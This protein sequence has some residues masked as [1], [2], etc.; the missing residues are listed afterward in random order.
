MFQSK[1]TGSFDGARRAR[2]VRERVRAGHGVMKRP[3]YIGIRIHI[4][5]YTERDKTGEKN[6]E[7]EEQRESGGQPSRVR[8]GSRHRQ[9]S[10]ATPPEW[11]GPGFKRSPGGGRGPSMGT[12]SFD[13][14]GVLDRLALFPKVWTT[15]RRLDT[16]PK[17][18]ANIPRA[19][20]THRRFGQHPEG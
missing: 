1:E 10:E 3:L 4:C 2:L 6:G 19:R 11:N 15:S 12:G 9:P 7:R 5:I 17:G 16:L 18:L 8:V 13:R 14:V 20:Q